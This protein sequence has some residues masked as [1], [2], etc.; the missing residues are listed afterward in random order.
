MFLHFLTDD[1]ER[2]ETWTSLDT[3]STSVGLL[4]NAIPMPVISGFQ[5]LIAT[6]PIGKLLKELKLA[7]CIGTVA[8]IQIH[9]VPAWQS[10]LSVSWTFAF[11]EQLASHILRHLSFLL[12]QVQTQLRKI[13]LV[14]VAKLNGKET[15]TFA[16]ATELIDPSKRTLRDLCFENEEVLPKESFFSRFSMAL[17]EIGLKTIV[18]EDLIESRVRCYSSGKYP[19]QDVRNRAQQLLASFAPLITASKQMDGS[20]VRSLAWLPTLDHNGTLSLKAS[21]ECRSPRSRLLVS[22]QLPIL[23]TT[24]SP[25]WEACLGW[26]GLLPSHTLL[27]Q[28]NYGIQEKDREIVDAVLRYISHNSIAGEVAEKLRDLRWVLGSNGSFYQPSK[29]F[30]RDGDRLQPYLVNVDQK[31]WQDHQ[32]LLAIGETPQVRDLL[33]IQTMLESKTALDE[34]DESVSNYLLSHTLQ[35]YGMRSLNVSLHAGHWN[36]LDFQFLAAIR[37]RKKE[38]L[39]CL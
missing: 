24:V 21:T 14:P 27:S 8:A 17:K 4:D 31:F 2:F 29:A 9:I 11:K 37:V 34:S 13:P 33:A 38:L 10:T 12:P 22:A 18:D 32:K 16:S 20:A 6:T 25:Q 30:R 26:D 28:L 19:V 36:I 15:S 39:I 5:F 3:R 1:R 7:D 23:T 35:V